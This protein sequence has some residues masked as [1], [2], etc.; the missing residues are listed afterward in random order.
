M[1]FSTQTIGQRGEQLAYEYLLEHEF[2][3]LEQNYRA[4]RYEIDIIAFKDGV[5]H[6]VEVKTRK[7]NSLTSP[8][9]AITEKKFQSLAKAAQ[10]YLSEGCYDYELSFDL[11][12]VEYDQNGVEISYVPEAMCAR[13]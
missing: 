7:K 6:I 11:I 1:S 8:S 13:W 3:V 12:A 2:H 4:G 10:Y 5:L 9:D